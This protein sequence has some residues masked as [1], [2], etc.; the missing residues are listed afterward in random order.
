MVSTKMTR[1]KI[2]E[3]THKKILHQLLLGNST[4]EKQYLKHDLLATHP[5]NHVYKQSFP[6]LEQLNDEF[7]LTWSTG[8]TYTSMLQDPARD[9][10]RV[11][12]VS[13]TKIHGDNN[14]S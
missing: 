11:N 8:S 3:D 10:I 13:D 12:M 2:C 14:P 5:Q 1:H 7:V 6:N 9:L 4:T